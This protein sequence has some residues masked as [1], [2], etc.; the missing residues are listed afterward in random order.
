MGIMRKLIQL[1]KLCEKKV[2]LYIYDDE[3]AHLYEY[4]NDEE[5]DLKNVL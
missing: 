4:K 1:S 5:F 3:L 2:I